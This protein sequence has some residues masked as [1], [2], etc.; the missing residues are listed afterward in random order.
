MQNTKLSTIINQLRGILAAIQCSKDGITSLS[1]ILSSQPY[2][3]P[4]A[5]HLCPTDTGIND[6]ETYGNVALPTPSCEYYVH[7]LGT[8]VR[9][10]FQFT[11][12]V[13]S[14]GFYF[15]M[16]LRMMFMAILC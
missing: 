4:L 5:T 9:Q 13:K 6:D 14:V 7:A 8:N 15:V 12:L 11:I 1:H 3:W 2:S 16:L 10:L